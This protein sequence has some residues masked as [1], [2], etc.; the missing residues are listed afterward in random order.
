MVPHARTPCFR[1]RC[2]HRA[3]GRRYGRGC[4]AA[5][6]AARQ[7]CLARP[8]HRRQGSRRPA[9][10]QQADV[11]RRPHPW[12][13][14]RRLLGSLPGRPGGREQPPDAASR[15]AAD[16]AGG[17][18]YLRQ[19]ARRR[20]LRAGVG[21][22]GD[23]RRLHARLRGVEERRAAR[24]RRRS[25]DARGKVVEHRRARGDRR[26]AG[27]AQDEA[28]RRRCG[29]REGAPRFAGVRDRRRAR[30][31]LL[32][33]HAGRRRDG[34]PPSSGPH[35]RCAQRAVQLGRG[36]HPHVQTGRRPRGAVRDRRSEARRHGR[37]LLPPG[38]AGDGD[39][40]GCAAC[41]PQR[42]ALRRLV[43]GLVAPR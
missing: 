42:V 12:R 28:D 30:R 26:D 15:R 8:A 11:R 38:A 7:R 31:R 18:R 17:A 19:F 23:P 9:R 13:A 20:L 14:L 35:R 36:Q 5:R 33:R 1:S 32:R 6:H 27:A 43:R 16:E 34:E 21:Q 3:P 22:P 39:A 10:Q 25:V 41:R 37:R 2:L 24:R 29:V 4:R 40:P